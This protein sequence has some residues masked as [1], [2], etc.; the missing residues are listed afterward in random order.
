MRLTGIGDWV[1]GVGRTARGGALAVALAIL[2]G[3]A[4]GQGMGYMPLD[5]PRLP[6]IE[7]RI[8]RGDMEDPS[9]GVRPFPWR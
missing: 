3:G 2:P 7:H 4:W 9:P 6:M 8:A 5:D 1:L